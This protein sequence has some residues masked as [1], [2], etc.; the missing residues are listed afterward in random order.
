MPRGRTESI[1]INGEGHRLALFRVDTW[2]EKGR[3]ETL[4]MIPEERV[5]ELGNDPDANHFWFAYVEWRMLQPN[6][7]RA[8]KNPLP[9]Q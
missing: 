2:D 7:G 6:P 9:D 1:R 4:T 8:G 3:P 5:V